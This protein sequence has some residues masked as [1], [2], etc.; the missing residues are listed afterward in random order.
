MRAL[1]NY[2]WISTNVGL[3]G[4]AGRVLRVSL[5]QLNIAE[6]G[7]IIENPDAFA[8]NRAQQAG[9]IRIHSGV[10]RIELRGKPSRS[11]QK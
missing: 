10:S 4:C 9:R 2:G 11:G 1:H 7:W 3:S 5:N 8:K 6:R